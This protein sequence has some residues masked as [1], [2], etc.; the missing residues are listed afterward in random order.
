VDALEVQHCVGEVVVVGV[1]DPPVHLPLGLPEDARKGV[2]RLALNCRVRHQSGD[3][4][5]LAEHLPYVVRREKDRRTHDVRRL[6]FPRLSPAGDAR[7]AR[8]TSGLVRSDARAYLCRLSSSPRPGG[9][10]SQTARRGL[11]WREC[12]VTFNE[13]AAGDNGQPRVV[14]HGT[15]RDFTDFSADAQEEAFFGR[16][17]E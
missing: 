7:F 10:R 2:R 13:T 17:L 16:E 8:R 11:P 5:Q 6:R 9:V 1:R 15:S 4:G 12:T 3:R 14:Y